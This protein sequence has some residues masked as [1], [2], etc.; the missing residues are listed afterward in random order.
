ME[1]EELPYKLGTIKLTW[2][3]PKDYTILASKIFS[4]I[5]EALKSI[6]KNI[7]S[8]EFLIFELVKSDGI[9]Y[10][11]KLL[12]FGLYNRFVKGMKFRNNKILY[13]GSMAL[14]IIGIIYTIKLVYSKL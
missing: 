2:V 11:W 14:T 6:P 1:N 13:Y 4:S 3:N 5:D 9:S 8:N 12:P 7:K 10:E